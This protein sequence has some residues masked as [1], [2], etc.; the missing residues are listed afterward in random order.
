MC[1]EFYSAQS[2][3]ASDAHLMKPLSS[4]VFTL[5]HTHTLSLSHTHSLSHDCQHIVR[6]IIKRNRR[7]EGRIPIAG[8]N[9]RATQQCFIDDA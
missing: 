7:F 3:V 6:T 1:K 2:I 9:R 5:S 4:L 8:D